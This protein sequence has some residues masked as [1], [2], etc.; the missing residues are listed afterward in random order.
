MCM[1]VYD[2]VRV[3]VCVPVCMCAC[4]R[5]YVRVC[6]CECVRARVVCVY[7]YACVFEVVFYRAGLYSRFHGKYID[8]LLL[9]FSVVFISWSSPKDG[10]T[11]I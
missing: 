8:V 1:F 6:A 3:R 9:L 5:A 10:E 4:I 7:V 11:Y 2:C